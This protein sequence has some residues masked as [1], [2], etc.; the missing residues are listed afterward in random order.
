MSEAKGDLILL[1]SRENGL[2]WF[3]LDNEQSLSPIF[4]KV[5]DPGGALYMFYRGRLGI[6]IFANFHKK[7][8]CTA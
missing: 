5:S 1:P 8:D 3:S 7:S 2:F 4:L 6:N